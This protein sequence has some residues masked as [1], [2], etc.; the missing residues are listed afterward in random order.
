MSNLMSTRM[1]RFTLRELFFITTLIAVLLCVASQ[2]YANRFVSR[3]I[4]QSADYVGYLWSLSGSDTP[5]SVVMSGPQWGE[6]VRGRHDDD[7]EQHKR[8]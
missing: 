2:G 4:H 7:A 8:D 1:P 6:E 3:C 5:N